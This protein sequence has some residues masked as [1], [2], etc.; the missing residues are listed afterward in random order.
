MW[1]GR[2][3]KSLL[4]TLTRISLW[5]S[6]SLDRTGQIFALVNSSPGDTG[7]P[8]EVKKELCTS[9]RVL[10]LLLPDVQSCVAVWV[11]EGAFPGEIHLGA[12]FLFA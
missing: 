10:F 12:S 8:K 2:F 11:G 7:I 1:S 9:E 5:L 4:L 6:L 3:G